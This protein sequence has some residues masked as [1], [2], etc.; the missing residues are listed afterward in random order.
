MKMYRFRL[1][2]V[3]F[4]SCC[5]LKIFAQEGKIQKSTEI[6]VI[7]G[8]SYYL[9]TVLPGQTLYSICKAYNVS[10]EELKK[11][12]DKKE[13]KLSIYE[14]LK[15][16]YIESFV[17]Q[18]DKYYYHKVA[19]GE[20]LYSI[21][22]H[23]GMKPRKL[24]KHNS[25][26]STY[27][28]LAVGAFVKVPLNGMDR[29][30]I[31]VAK[32][33]NEI[34]Y[35]DSR[36]SE[37][38]K[39]EKVNATRD[40]VVL[41]QHQIVVADTVKEN[42]ISALKA[43]VSSDSSVKIALVLPLHAREYP[44]YRDS[45]PDFQTVRVEAR[46]E[47]F[48]NFYEG[49]LLAVDSLKK[50]GSRIQLYVFDSEKNP[51][52][53]QSL[54]NKLNQL[55][56]DLIIGPV[57]ASVAKVLVDNLED[58]NTPIVFPL[59]ARGGNLAVYKNVVQVNSSFSGLIMNMVEWLK[60]KSSNANIIHIR[61]YNEGED[62]AERQILKEQF[63][64]VVGMYSFTWD[65]ERITLDSLKSM[66]VPEQEN[67]IVIPTTKEADVSKILPVLTAF[68]GNYQIS[69]IGLPEWQ[70]FSSI[71]FENFYKLDT[72]LFTYCYVDYFS[73]AAKCL[74]EKY[75]KYFYSEPST[76]VYKAFDMGM[77][78]IGLADTYGYNTLDAI[79]NLAQEKDFSLF[80]FGKISDGVALEN[81][82]FYIVH[83]SSD[84]QIKIE[85][86]R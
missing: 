60:D 13:D 25:E 12:N 36:M 82:A 55:A 72:K 23:Y 76:L 17:S 70:Q 59:S 1:L 61:T 63:A 52:K 8:E 71:D 35:K 24:I 54:A 21:A 28:P 74:A 31:P 77:Y 6:V 67:I 15:V 65:L 30:K 27:R 78:F 81:Q 26:Y 19:K 42:A 16:P 3:V 84:Y 49:I 68:A 9:H 73:N 43:A 20:T 46:S 38:Q 50:T 11:L 29:S 37:G 22:R 4:L 47:Q 79:S 51:V 57:Y 66:L 64:K 83:F 41:K 34:V 75:R 80:K 69:V 62:A 32:P 40:S 5:F 39:A 18:D 2:L 48:L 44:D 45:L 85:K 33:E 10:V 58:K 7:R 56:P 14:V 53:M 86:Y